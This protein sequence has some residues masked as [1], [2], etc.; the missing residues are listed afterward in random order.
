MD[1]CLVGDIPGLVMTD[2][3]LLKM[4]ILMGFNGILWELMVI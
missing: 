3:L 4:A 2:S 1:G